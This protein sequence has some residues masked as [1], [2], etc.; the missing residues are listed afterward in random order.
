[1]SGAVSETIAGEGSLLLASVLFGAGL[2]MLYDM[3]RIFRHLLKHKTAFL[4]VEDVRYWL[5][6]AVG[7]FALLYEEN[8]GLLRWFVI[9]GA[10]AGMLLE[11]KL[12]SPFIVR[13]FVWILK[14]WIK[15]IRKI[16]SV[17]TKPAKKVSLFFKKELKK[18]RKAFKIGISKQ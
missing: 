15:L 6:C 5:I 9:G 17:F 1:M 18:I 4:A 12:L 3:L 7:I 14:K 2:M 10:A 11:N 16:V 13:F 8:G